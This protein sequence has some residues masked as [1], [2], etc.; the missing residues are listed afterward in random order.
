MEVA[1]A[2]L[3][4]AKGA[5]GTTRTTTRVA[6]PLICEACST[7]W[8]S[9]SGYFLRHEDAIN[10]LRAGSSFVMHMKMNVPS[11][12]VRMLYAAANSWRNIKQ[13]EPAKLDGPMRASLLYCLCM[14]FKTRLEEIVNKDEALEKMVKLS[15]VSRSPVLTWAYLRWDA[16]SKKMT[17]DTS[18]PPLSHTEVLEH[19]SKIARLCP[20]QHALARFH[21]TRPMAEEMRGDS[22]VFLVQTGQHGEA[23][24]ELRDSLRLLCH[25][26]AFHLLALQLKMDR[27][28]RSKL[29][30][31]LSEAMR[32][33]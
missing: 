14:E 25:C 33:Y 6:R 11:S 22:L 5:V 20:R 17:V 13:K 27:F 26:S 3:A 19:V 24:T 4:V 2:T 10:L 28:A 31:A 16:A 15:W 9:C 21:L 8:S 7:R 18:Q 30:V 32:S 23:P 1:G 29:A 12:V